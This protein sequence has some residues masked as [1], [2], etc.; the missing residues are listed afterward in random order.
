AERQR[1]RND[2]DIRELAAALNEECLVVEG[3]VQRERSADKQPGD[4]AERET[5]ERGQGERGENDG[6]LP[7]AALERDRGTR[8]EKLEMAARDRDETIG[9]YVPG[10]HRD[11]RG[12]I[13]EAGD[14]LGRRRGGGG[15]QVVESD[16]A[17][18]EVVAEAADLADL[19]DLGRDVHRKVAVV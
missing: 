8:R 15:E 17:V 4:E 3:V 9:R 16:D 13:D 14:R 7:D 10:D 2:H 12:R 11:V 19:K 18:R 6:I 1:G 5:R